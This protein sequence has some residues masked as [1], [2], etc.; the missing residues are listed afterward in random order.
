MRTT[1][2]VQKTENKPITKTISKTLAIVLSLVL[3]S[4][5]VSAQGFWKQILVNNT[6]G[7]MA[8]LM[9]E[10]KNA[11]D[12]LFKANAHSPETKVAMPV[13]HTGTATQMT[14]ECYFGSQWGESQNITKAHAPLI[15][16]RL[17]ESNQS[18]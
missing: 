5:T 13:M 9:V 10:Q 7:K 11:D 6:Y 18:N 15:D 3:I 1:S 12:Q 4:F 16:W 17:D 14:F 8:E 2:K